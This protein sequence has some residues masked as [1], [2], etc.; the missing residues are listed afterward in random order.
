MFHRGRHHF[1]ERQDN[2]TNGSAEP[3]ETLVEAS[4]SHE[5]LESHPLTEEENQEF[6]R[7]RQKE[8]ASAATKNLGKRAVRRNMWDLPDWYQQQS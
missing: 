7:Q 1:F 5:W 3:E 2:A 8:A 6:E 4:S